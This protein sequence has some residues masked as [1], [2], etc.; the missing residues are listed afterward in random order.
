[1]LVTSSRNT[2]RVIMVDPNNA[3]DLVTATGE[4]RWSTAKGKQL[5]GHQNITISEI[6]Q[7]IK[8]RIPAGKFVRYISEAIM[9]PPA[10]SSA[11]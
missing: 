3:G 4:Y 6:V 7:G 8:P 10:D 9:R 11:P 1:M 5:V 2:I